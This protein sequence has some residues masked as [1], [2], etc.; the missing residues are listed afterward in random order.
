MKKSKSAKYSMIASA[1]LL[2]VSLSAC[3]GSTEEKVLGR[4][5]IG[6]L[7]YFSDGGYVLAFDGSGLST[8]CKL[9]DGATYETEP[10][11]DTTFKCER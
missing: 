8:G 3:G 1:V 9:P 5:D 4:T 11:I 6:K 2:A 7:G 10:L